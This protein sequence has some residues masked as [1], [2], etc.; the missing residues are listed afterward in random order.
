[1]GPAGNR[2]L[3]FI[4]F[5]GI[6]FS[7]SWQ[8]FSAVL[9]IM[10]LFLAVYA[11]T[12]MV[13]RR[14]DPVK[15]LS[16]VTVLILLPYI[17]LLLY[18]FFGMHY[19]KRRLYKF[20]GNAEYRYRK[21][22][23]RYQSEFIKQ[24]PQVLGDL[25]PYK[26]IIF[27][28]LRNSYTLVENNSSID[29]FF[30]GKEALD[31]M[32]K[33]IEGAANHI[34]LQSYIFENDRTGARFAKLLME[35]A[36][37]GVEVRVIYDGVGS[38]SLKKD[39]VDAMKRAGVEMLC[40]AKV[41]ITLPTSKIN[42][43]NH[44]KILVVDGNCGFLG[45]VNIADRYYYGNA[46]GPWH[47]THMKIVGEAVSS[48]QTSFLL[49]RY[50]ILNRKLKMRK[51]YY[52]QLEMRQRGEQA[53]Q[54][55]I[56]TQILASGPDSNWS[57]IMQCFFSAITVARNHIYIVSPYFTPNESVLNAI[58]IAALGNV[59]VRIMLPDKSDTKI[60]HYSTM[61]YVGELLE[62]GVKIY[63]FKKGFN[64][65]KVVSIDG[66]VSIVGSANMDM[67]SFEHNFEILSVIYDKG[68]AAVIE[69]QFVDDASACRELNLEMWRR[70]SR[71][72]K[73]LESVSRLLSPLL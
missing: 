46:L 14:Q 23:S 31:A 1:M 60:A 20:K 30:S 45:G 70:R 62:A 18:F 47:D 40:F 33:A 67:R 26:K 34:H 50:F 68:C 28:N 6:M 57:S 64:H 27:Q 63:L 16:W 44:R 21:E 73:V 39:F 4:P 54:R 12:S 58:K 13:M 55:S 7:S 59:D 25:E 35:K 69:N 2:R 53:P 32:Y 38:I 10:N 37:Q 15:T 9:Y 71:R 56:A 49:D 72:Q 61:S 36:A 17:G 5:P 66:E 8:I 42:Y 51:R 48:L 19:R 3:P 52:P 43:R 65:S 11:A 24:N 29:F 41:D 22:T